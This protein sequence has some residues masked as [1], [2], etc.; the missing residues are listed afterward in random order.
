MA[1]RWPLHNSYLTLH[2]EICVSH[3]EA[4][5]LLSDIGELRNTKGSVSSKEIP[6]MCSGSKHLYK[7][8]VELH[9]S[10]ML[11]GCVREKPFPPSGRERGAHLVL[12][13]HPFLVCVLLLC[14][15]LL[16]KPAVMGNILEPWEYLSIIR[17][18]QL[19]FLHAGINVAENE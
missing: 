10:V 15:L 11:G 3:T 12:H 6:C 1:G 5:L 14:P 17:F 9:S 16:I 19:P 13:H 8:S 18:T 4:V 2:A 7:P